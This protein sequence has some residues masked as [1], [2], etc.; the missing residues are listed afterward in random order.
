MHT[1]DT[2]VIGAGQAGLSLSRHLTAAGHAHAVLERGRIGERWHSERWDSLTLLTPGWLNRLDGGEAHPDPDGFLG[3]ADFVAYLDRYARSFSA[4][5]HEHVTVASVE[6]TGHGFRVDTN[7]G[8]WRARNVVIATGDSS[9]PRMPAAAASAPRQLVQ[10]HASRYRNPA[11][12]PDGGVL[13]VGAGPSGQQIAAELRRAGRPVVLAVGRHARVPRRYR[14]RDIWHWLDAI[15]DLERTIDEVPDPAASR[16]APSLALS[17]AHGGEQLDLSV[18]HGLGVT[19]TGRLETFDAGRVV[20][21]DDLQP[22]IDDAERRMLRLLDR[23]D[24]HVARAHGG[25]WPHPPDRPSPVRL[26][27]APGSL[28]V[29]GHGISTVVWATGYR[30]DYPWLHVPVL[31]PDGE[32]VHRHGITPVPGLY[33]LGL[34]FQRRRVSHFIGGVGADA[35][36]IA[37]RIAGSG[38]P[39]KQ[40]RRAASPVLRAGQAG[41]LRPTADERPRGWGVAP[42]ATRRRRCHVSRDRRRGTG[43]VAGK[44]ERAC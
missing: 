11:A 16:R 21:A 10:I 9:E 42:M 24:A 31:G 29:A 17:G 34:K 12:L 6:R 22:A 37:R 2:L 43:E 20:F 41:L 28:D 4:P 15:G 44:G 13:V 36:W 38:A 7:T 30:R 19:V 35:A 25:R 27:A 23:I 40:P 5:V 3:R 14:G 1:T 26:A 32:I 33:A 39:E 18:L 8:V